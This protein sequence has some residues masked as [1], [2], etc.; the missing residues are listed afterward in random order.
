LG[1]ILVEVELIQ[2]QDLESA[3]LDQ[4]YTDQTLAL[5]KKTA[6]SVFFVSVGMNSKIWVFNGITD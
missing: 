4:Y 3:L 6:V 1:E 2:K 5:S